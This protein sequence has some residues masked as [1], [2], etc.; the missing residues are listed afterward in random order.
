M[1]KYLWEEHLW[2]HS[3]FAASCDGAPPSTIKESDNK[4]RPD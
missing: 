3:Y 1:H 2:S 4:M